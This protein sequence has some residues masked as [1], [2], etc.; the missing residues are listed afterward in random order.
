MA[1]LNIIKILIIVLTLGIT[2]CYEYAVD[3]NDYCFEENTVI[4]TDPNS[5]EMNWIEVEGGSFEMGCTA[6]QSEVVVYCNHDELPIHT[7]SLDSYMIAQYEVTNEQ[8]VKFLNSHVWDCAYDI[9]KLDDKRILSLELNINNI[10]FVN[11][12]FTVNDSLMNYPATAYREGMKAFCEWVGGRLPTEAEWEFAARGGNKSK[13]YV[14]SGSNDIHAVA[15][16][17]DDRFILT[18]VGVFPPNELGIYDMA[19]NVVEH[20]NDFYDEF[21]YPEDS[22]HNPLGPDLESGIHVARGHRVSS[23]NPDSWYH[24][25]RCAK[26]IP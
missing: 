18:E 6:E 12:I 7:V 16:Y 11:G 1:N 3:G 14:Y 9:V 20:C 13:G 2:S 4:V 8:F 15:I 17:E 23:R 24:G 10:K 19:G 26:D 21:Y 5:I 25:C 22:V